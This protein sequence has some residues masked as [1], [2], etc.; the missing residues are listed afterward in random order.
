MELHEIRYF[1]AISKT[2][3]FTKAAEA[4][5]VSQP[6]LT[7]AIHKLEDELGGLLF[8]RERNNT[9]LTELGR[10]IEPHLREVIAQ[11]GEVKQAAARF[12]TLEK[13]SLS[14]GVMCTIA[15]IQFVSF[16]V[17]FRSDNPGVEITL[18]ESVPSRLSELLITGELDVALMSRPDGFARPLQA[19]ALYPER[20]VIAC[21][22]GHRFARRKYI[23]IAEL[24][25]EF[26]CELIASF[27][28]SWVKCAATKVR[29]CFGPTRANAK[30]GF[31][32]WSQRGSASAFFQSIQQA[33]RVLSAVPS[34]QR[35][36][37]RCVS[38]R[39]QD[40]A[41]RHRWPPLFT[42]FLDT[43]GRQQLKHWATIH[44]SSQEVIVPAS[45]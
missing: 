30:T 43:P 23:Q 12:L 10:L 35:S 20:F 39:F 27:R 9:H 4:C 24:D 15:P 5:Q 1:L 14:I 3:N 31:C 38:L 19:C 25:G 36:S 41:D 17:H 22:A 6:A 44:Y 8:S 13:A 26:Y 11:E 45:V 37:E 32:T 28:T 2:L 21:S 7:R 33:S 29:S 34:R 16:L 40:A 18:V 42:R